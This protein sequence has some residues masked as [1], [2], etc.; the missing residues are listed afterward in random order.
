MM[1]RP[2]RVA[3]IHDLSCSIPPVFGRSPARF[4]SLHP[5]WGLPGP[6]YA[7]F[8]ILPRASA[9]G[10]DTARAADSRSAPRHTPQAIAA[11]AG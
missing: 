4:L 10:T 9:A 1:T 8:T 2:Q 11:R 7:I 5:L 6:F 3:A